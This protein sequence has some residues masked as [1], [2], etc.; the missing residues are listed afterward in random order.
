MQDLSPV[1][2]CE[3]QCGQQ[4]KKRFVLGHNAKGSN[5]RSWKGGR[6]K[7]GRYTCH[8]MPEHPNADKQGYVFAHVLIAENALGKFLPIG[9]IVHHID[10]DGNNN[11]KN[12]L[13]ICQDR[14][15]H[16]LLHQRMRALKAFGNPNARKCKFCKQ[17]G[18]PDGTWYTKLGEGSRH[19]RCH[20]EY[21]QARKLK[22]L[23][24]NP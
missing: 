1:K 23:Q 22:S 12:N 6:R 18:V 16:N 11:H 24:H 2:F 8:L 9:T 20:A 7:S 21:E 4:V 15:Y 13:V 14:A 3:C 10:E 19:K 5:N 17:W